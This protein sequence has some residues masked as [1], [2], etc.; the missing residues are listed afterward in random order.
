MS[1]YGRDHGLAH[2]TQEGQTLRFPDSWRQPTLCQAE[3]LMWRLEAETTPSRGGGQNFRQVWVEAITAV[4]YRSPECGSKSVPGVLPP[5]GLP[6]GVVTGF[7]IYPECSLN[8]PPPIHCFPT[9][10]RILFSGVPH[11]ALH[12][13]APIRAT[14]GSR[15][16]QDSEF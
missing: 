4:F 14:V 1:H 12:A 8:A 9:T 7:S 6:L 5:T 2:S 13:S 16:R 10:V 3:A 11:P 15:D